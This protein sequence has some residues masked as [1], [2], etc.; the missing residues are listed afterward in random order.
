VKRALAIVNLAI[1]GLLCFS[2]PSLFRAVIEDHE[3][4][5]ARLQRMNA[6]L[7]DDQLFAYREVSRTALARHWEE[8]SSSQQET[9][10]GTLR[11]LIGANYEKALRRSLTDWQISYGKEVVIDDEAAVEAT[12]RSRSRQ[13]PM[14]FRMKRIGG[15]WMIVDIITDDVSMVKTYRVQFDKLIRTRGFD[16]TLEKMKMKRDEFRNALASS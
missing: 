15:S 7:D 12:A 2:L 16:G 11:E 5:L 4:P 10:V 1:A 14:T 13:E 9:F 6:G 8:L 3:A